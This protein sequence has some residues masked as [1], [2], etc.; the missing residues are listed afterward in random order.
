MLVEKDIK[1][2]FQDLEEG[3]A[4]SVPYDGASIQARLVDSSSK[5]YL[6]AAIYFGGNYIPQSVRR[7][8]G[9][10]C[11]DT[12]PSIRTFMTIDEREFRIHLNYLGHAES[13]D[14]DQFKGLIAEFGWIAE[15]WRLY[16]DEHDKNDLIHVRVK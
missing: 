2:A 16:L 14:R 4:V 3:E 9:K 15:K 13:L 12:H 11:P 8:L 7:C 6:S 5:L 10:E 1:K